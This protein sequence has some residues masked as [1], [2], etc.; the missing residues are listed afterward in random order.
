VSG[1]G[2]GERGFTLLEL[3]VSMTLLALVLGL[4]FGGLRTGTRVWE[5]GA[6]RGDDLARLQAVHGFLRRQLGAL[7]PLAQRQRNLAPRS[8][9]SGAR[10]AVSFT[11]FL[12]SHF[13]FVGFQVIVVG[14]AE[15]DD[16][17]HLGAWWYP[18]DPD[19]ESPPRLPEEQ[20][21][22]LIEDVEAIE[23]A[24]YGAPGRRAEP[25]WNDYWQ[26][27]ERPPRLIRLRVEFADGDPRTWP[28]LV[29]RPAIDGTLLLGGE[30]EEPVE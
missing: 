13:G 7:Q 29:V 4:L 24:Y 8:T 9:F 10:E 14:V 11:G 12:P 22:L 6:R 17:R 30:E 18:F 28:E 27:M 25:Q 23:F 1:T 20:Q 5:A 16:G 15:D 26:D 19:G 3:L 21:T 2:R